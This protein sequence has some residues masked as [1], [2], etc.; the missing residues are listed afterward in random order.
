MGI[1]L[2]DLSPNPGSTRPRKRIGRGHGSG[3]H[4]TAGKGTKG[5]KA[6]TG[7]HGIPKPGFEGGQTAMARRLPKRGFKNPFRKEIFA[8]NLGDIAAHFVA[9]GTSID[10]AQ[11]R[12][13]GLV[14]RSAKLVKVLGKIREGQHLA[15]QIS[16]HVHFISASAR[17]QLEA[18]NGAFHEITVSPRAK[19]AT[20]A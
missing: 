6:R 15:K 3:T 7:H 17:K 16:L 4:K 20:E 9:A 1:T 14:P 11:L 18:L 10:L 19:T 2:Q 8:V 12:T 13:A 5:Q